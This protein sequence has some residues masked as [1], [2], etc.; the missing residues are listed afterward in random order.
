MKKDQ[1]VVGY[2]EALVLVS[3]RPK[4]VKGY[5]SRQRVTIDGHHR[6]HILM[7]GCLYR[8]SRRLTKTRKLTNQEPG[9]SH[10]VRNSKLEISFRRQIG[11]MRI[12][13]VP[14]VSK[15]EGR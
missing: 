15:A 5:G 2:N 9:T 12:Q 3:R 8:Q 4:L 1:V 6:L 14:T 7:T 13:E 10:Q 11:F